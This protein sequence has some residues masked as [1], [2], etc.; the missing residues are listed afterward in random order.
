METEDVRVLLVEDDLSNA[1]LV[2]AS[3]ATV[4]T[5]N[6]QVEHCTCWADAVVLLESDL[7]IDVVLLNLNLPDVHVRERIQEMRA[8]ADA[9]PI[10]VL[11]GSEVEDLEIVGWLRHEIQDCLSKDR[12]DALTLAR[13]IRFAIERQKGVL[14]RQKS[15]RNVRNQ[16]QSNRKEEM[17]ESAYEFVHDTAH[18]FRSALTVVK[19]YVSLVRDGTLGRIDD[20]QLRVLRIAEDRAEQL[21]GM[22]DDVSNVFDLNAGKLTPYRVACDMGEILAHAVS[23]LTRRATIKNIDLQADLYSDLPKIYCDQR[24]AKQIVNRLVGHAMSLMRADGSVRVSAETN[25]DFVGVRVTCDRAGADPNRLA[26]SLA[27]FENSGQKSASSRSHGIG[28]N[29]AKELANLNFGSISVVKEDVNEVTFGVALPVHE[30]Q[31]LIRCYLDWYEDHG[32]FDSV[33]I[34][35]AVVDGY[36]TEEQLWDIDDLINEVLPIDGFA[37]ELWA[38]QWC[39]LVPGKDVEAAGFI[40]R[41][42]RIQEVRSQ[43][44]G[45]DQIDRIACQHV[46]S[47]S[48]SDC[49]NRV[50]KRPNWIERLNV[51]GSNESAN[52]LA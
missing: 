28:F 32:N 12:W 8:Q 13:S 22:V 14:D 50:W 43:T 27:S 9:V 31:S 38:N 36:K 29:L 45:E 4:A 24:M 16:W 11:S 15:W 34:V 18:D 33:A 48:A 41:L 30:P 7:A 37:V 25:D 5:E 3:L 35:R 19:E 51:F 10:L 23:G 1:N 52:I 2:K 42:G 44:G 39:I 49:R 47:L 46:A 40:H 26:L 17:L 6:F 21:N 20:E